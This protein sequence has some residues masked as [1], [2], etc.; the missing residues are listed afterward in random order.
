MVV[1]PLTSFFILYQIRLLRSQHIRY[2][3]EGMRYLAPGFIALD[4]RYTPLPLVIP[5][6]LVFVNT[7]LPYGLLSLL[8]IAPLSRPWI[9]YWIMHSLDL[10]EEQEDTLL[11]SD[12]L[13]RAVG[14]CHT[15]YGV[16]LVYILISSC[17]GLLS[18]QQPWPAVRILLVGLEEGLRR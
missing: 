7:P 4:A 18:H 6:T 2:L 17:D 11:T 1:I 3:K 12:L 5:F 13:H 9:C 14:R 10:L 8:C 15:H 16:C